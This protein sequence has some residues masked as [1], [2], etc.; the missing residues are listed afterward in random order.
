MTGTNLIEPREWQKI[1]LEVIVVTSREHFNI[2]YI[3]I[4]SKDAVGEMATAWCD[5]NVELV[6]DMYLFFPFHAAVCRHALQYKI[7]VSNN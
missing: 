6:E 2:R 1:P 7:I 4:Y 3:R 5:E